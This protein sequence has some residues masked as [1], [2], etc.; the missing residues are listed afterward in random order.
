MPLM[1]APTAV[2]LALVFIANLLWFG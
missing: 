2:V 1:L